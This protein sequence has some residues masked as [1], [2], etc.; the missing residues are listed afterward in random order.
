[1]RELQLIGA[2]HGTTAEWALGPKFF[3]VD[4]PEGLADILSTTGGAKSIAIEAIPG[5]ELSAGVP[6]YEADVSFETALVLARGQLLFGSLAKELTAQ[7]HTVT[8]IDSERIRA[9][10][11]PKLLGTIAK[12]FVWQYLGDGM[13]TPRQ[14]RRIKHS[15]AIIEH[16]DSSVREEHMFRELAE[17]DFDAAILGQ[18]HADVLAADE[19]LQRQLG[20]QVVDYVQILPDVSGDNPPIFSRDS[21]PSRT[22]IPTPDE[23][24]DLARR[25]AVSRELARRKYNAYSVGRILGRG[26]AEP[27]FLGRFYITGPAAS[28]LF[29]LFVHEQDGADFTGAAYDAVGDAAVEGTLSS[30]EIAFTKIYD[31]STVLSPDIRPLFYHGTINPDDGA[32][33]GRWEINREHISGGFLHSMVPFERK[34]IRALDKKWGS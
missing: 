6:N 30:D 23:L 33:D 13:L 8:G 9:G 12:H 5:H 25:H 28:S 1:M 34:A 2:A 24:A 15:R 16:I 27:N 14:E 10:V 17:G 18:A 11:Y 7:G 3:E 4:P 19:R 21:V 32:I 20:L 29:E 22:H 26:H 31:P